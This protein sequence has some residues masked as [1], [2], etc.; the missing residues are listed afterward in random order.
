MKKIYISI[1]L[2]YL[3]LSKGY[4]VNA[5]VSK[6]LFPGVNCGVPNDISKSKCCVPMKVSFKDFFSPPDFGSGFSLIRSLILGPARIFLEST[7]GKK[8][9]CW[10]QN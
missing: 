1:F 4:I 9:S 8:Y 6:Y 3:I 2:L 7:V 5:Q 10:P